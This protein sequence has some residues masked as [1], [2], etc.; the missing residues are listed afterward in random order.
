MLNV[1]KSVSDVD[2]KPLTAVGPMIAKIFSS[3]AVNLGASSGPLGKF[4]DT[5]TNERMK[6]VWKNISA[7]M[8]A[9][10]DTKRCSDDVKKKWQDWS[11]Q[12]KGKKCRLVRNYRATGGGPEEA[13]KF[14]TFAYHLSYLLIYFVL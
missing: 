1:S 9:V 12:V 11:S 6:K 13:P 4:S 14:F 7:K 10:G 5:T 8:S 2:G 3:I